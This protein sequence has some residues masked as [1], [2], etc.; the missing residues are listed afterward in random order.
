MKI[1]TNWQR[2]LSFVSTGESGHEILMDASR[3][4]GGEDRGPRPMELLLHGLAG[5]MGID[6]VMI[7]K[8]M[9]AEIADLEIEVEGERA[10]EHPR[11]FVTINIKFSLKGRGLTE[12][13]V[14]RAVK[15]SEDKY[16]SAG[17]SLN[18]DITT[19]YTFSNEE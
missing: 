4:A 19:E 18:A 11:R 10:E 6:V 5:C 8:K 17:N 16:C 12:K 1:T 14:N 13:N 2:G 3:E 15:L 7:L 9:Q